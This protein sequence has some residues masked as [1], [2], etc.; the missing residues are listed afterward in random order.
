MLYLTLMLE[1]WDMFFLLEHVLN[2]EEKDNIYTV[3]GNSCCI[4]SETRLTNNDFLLVFM[5]NKHRG[6]IHHDLM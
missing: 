2:I 1:I 4:W 3:A 5:I 6:Q